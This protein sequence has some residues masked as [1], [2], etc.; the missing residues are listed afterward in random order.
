[1][2]KAIH[3]NKQAISENC[4]KLKIMRE[5]KMRSHFLNP[6]TDD[7]SVLLDLIRKLDTSIAQF[8]HTKLT[9]ISGAVTD[10]YEAYLEQSLLP[11]TEQSSE[12][13]LE[14]IS[15]LFK[16]AVRWHYPGTLININPPPL[17][18]A[19]AASTYASLFNPNLA[20]DVPCGSLALAELEVIKHVADLAGWNWKEAHGIFTF[21]GKGTNLYAVK[22]GLHHYS[23]NFM[24]EGVNGEVAVFSTQQGHPCHIEVCDWLGIGKNRCIRLPV[25][26]TGRI[27]L[28]KAEQIMRNY[29]ANGGKIACIIT[30]GGSTLYNTIDP[31]NEIAKLRDCFVKEFN[32]IYK[33]HLHV[34]AVIGWAWL[35]FKDYDFRN[36]PLAIDEIALEKIHDTTARISEVSVADSFGVDFHKTGFC[37]TR[38]PT[39]FYILQSI[40]YDD[41]VWLSSAKNLRSY[42]CS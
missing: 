6:E 41:L 7:I 14:D 40:G 24:N 2:A 42:R 28:T 5:F 16:G 33:P 38:L 37:P 11:D 19:I 20:M 32:M 8:K 13:A 4:E 10:R 18:P 31:I 21:G 30:N 29:L 22:V 9:R 36:N 17:L 27:D 12:K 35:F 25:D 15:M 3:T 39:S 1:V 23:S 26:N 34:D